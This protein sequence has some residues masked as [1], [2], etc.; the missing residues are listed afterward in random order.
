VLELRSKLHPKCTIW[1]LRPLSFTSKAR[2]NDTEVTQN[3]VFWPLN[4][5]HNPLKTTSKATAFRRPAASIIDLCIV[6][7][8]HIQKYGLSALLGTPACDER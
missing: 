1:A 7:G 4:P 6:H 8:K 5:R 3:D 2:E